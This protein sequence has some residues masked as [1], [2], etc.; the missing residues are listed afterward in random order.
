MARIVS[1]ALALC[2]VIGVVLFVQYDEARVT[3]TVTGQPAPST[4]HD[5]AVDP[6]IRPYAVERPEMSEAR[7]G[8][9]IYQCKNG[10]ETVFSDQP[11][12][13][14]IA[15]TTVLAPATDPQRVRTYREQ[16]DSLVMNRPVVTSN[17]PV[18]LGMTIGT[19][20]NTAHCE[21]LHQQIARIDAQARQRNAP[22]QQDHLRAERRK[23]QYIIEREC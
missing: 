4:K 16:Y 11:C 6:A 13:N 22:Q 2:L 9:S 15:Q 17:G 20:K 10:G 18:A 19:G 5:A 12:G 23:V 8:A 14:V 7:S 21:S 1:I 3:A